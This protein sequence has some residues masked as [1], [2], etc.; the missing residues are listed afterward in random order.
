[1]KAILRVAAVLAS[2]ASI[3]AAG[4]AGVRA[5]S[6]DPGLIGGTLTATPTT[7]TLTSTATMPTHVVVTPD[8]PFA[9]NP[10]AFDIAPGES[11][12]M[13]VSGDPRGTVSARLS[14]LSAGAGDASSV[15]LNVG[16]PEPAPAPFPWGTVAFLVAGAFIVA[17]GLVAVRR[18]SR[19]YA[20][21]RKE[22]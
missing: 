20:I 2:V 14:V 3:A 21:V 5:A 18:L 12:A 1:M 16:F 9:L 4:A 7:V 11:V 17:R 10:S 19:R 8:G 15:T 13:S 22:A 6:P